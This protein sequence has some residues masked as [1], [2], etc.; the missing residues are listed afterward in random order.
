MESNRPDS[1][2]SAIGRGREPTPTFLLHE[3][4]KASA[5]MLVEQGIIPLPLGAQLAEAL[6]RTID[7][8]NEAGTP[9]PFD[10]LRFERTLIGIAGPNGSLLHAGRSRQ[11]ITATIERMLMRDLLLQAFDGINAARRSLLRMAERHANAIVPAYTWG[12]QAQPTS[13]GHYLLGYCDALARTN[14]RMREGL[15]RLNQSP[16]GSGALGTSSFPLNRERL[17]EL[18]GFP[19]LVVNSF[20]AVQISP[21]DVG[22]EMGAIAISASLLI[23]AFAADITA[24][25]SQV[26]PWLSMTEGTL[27]GISS[28]MPQKRNPKGLIVLRAHA[29]K[30]IGMAQAFFLTAHNVQPGMSDYKPLIIDPRGSHPPVDVLRELGTLFKDFQALVD[31]LKLDERRA[32]EEVQSDYSTTTELADVLQRD[33]GVPFRIGHEFASDLVSYG[34][35]HGCTPADL[36]Y[37]AAQR[38]YAAIMHKQDSSQQSLPLSEA[39]FRQALCAEHMVASAR[40]TGGPQAAEVRRMLDITC[41]SLEEDEHWLSGEWARLEAATGRLDEAFGQLAGAKPA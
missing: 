31:V 13:F 15:A 14:Q 19:A 1:S 35:A 10:Y 21:I 5:V 2:A 23:G 3:L 34:R 18:L 40:G 4:N 38:I 26:R 22:A 37:E 8:E 20:D 27:T 30:L 17:A 24:Q 7:I 28:M 33:A 36:P 41:K 6:C 11:D 9:L 25:Y 16:L 12:V 32:L 29:S 39:A